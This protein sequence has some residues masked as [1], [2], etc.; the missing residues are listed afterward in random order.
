MSVDTDQINGEKRRLV[1]FKRI[2]IIKKLAKQVEYDMEEE[3]RFSR[4]PELAE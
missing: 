2:D 1:Y 3:E 4:K